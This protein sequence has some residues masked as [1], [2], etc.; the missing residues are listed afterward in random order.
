MCTFCFSN[1]ERLQGS[2]R[3]LFESGI[4]KNANNKVFVTTRMAQFILVNSSEM[5]YLSE[6]D[7]PSGYKFGV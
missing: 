4:N 6:T 1:L 7:Y 3:F 2:Y 5:N